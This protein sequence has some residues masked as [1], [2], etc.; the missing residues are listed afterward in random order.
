M[1]LRS[2]THGLRTLSQWTLGVVPYVFYNLTREASHKLSALRYAPL[3]TPSDV[4]IP[5]R[6]LLA[7][8]VARSR[9]CAG[10]CKP[11]EAYR[12]RPV[13]LAY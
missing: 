9:E 13:G 3:F 1:V 7:V 5:I 12:V 8:D 6:L 4:G 11:R 2:P 10:F